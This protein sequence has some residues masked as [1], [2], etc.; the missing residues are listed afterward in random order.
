MNIAVGCP[1]QNRAFVFPSWLKSVRA[2]FDEIGVEPE[3]IFEYGDSFD[4][5]LSMLTTF[6]DGPLPDVHGAYLQVGEQHGWTDARY[7]EMAEIRNRLLGNVRAL[8]PDYFLS[9]DSDI[10][11]APGVLPNLLETIET[12]DCGAVGGKL[13]MS[14]TG[15][16]NPSYGQLMTYSGGLRRD[17]AEGVFPVDVIM[18][19]KLMSPAAYHVDYQGHFQG[20]DIGWCIGC[21]QAGVKLIWDG[22]ITSK[23]IMRPAM[24][25][26]IDERCGY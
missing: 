2:A 3:Y 18:A 21:Q 16:F 6:E 25:D 8:A 15:R 12:R 26:V 19:M 5:T 14:S 24:L 4:E 13:Y 1:I 17:D 20:E 7:V 22:R 10:L 11:I 9:L 23:H